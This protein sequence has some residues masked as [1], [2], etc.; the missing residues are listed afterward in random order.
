[1]CEIQTK[2]QGY[3]HFMLKEIYEQPKAITDTIAGRVGAN[4][5]LDLTGEIPKNMVKNLENIIFIGCGTAYHASLFGKHLL[6]EY[7][8]IYVSVEFASEYPYKKVRT[9]ERTLV[10]VISQSGET[11]DTLSAMRA[12]AAKGGKIL[13]ITNVVG[14][15]IARE[16]DAVLYT[17]AG[18]EVAVASTKAYVCQLTC[19]CLLAAYI[20]EQNYGRFDQDMI[21]ELKLIPEKINQTLAVYEGTLE[22]YANRFRDAGDAFFLGRGLDYAS[23]MEGQLKLKETTYIHGEALAGGEFRHGPMALIEPDVLVVAL[24]TQPE[25]VDK[26][27]SVLKEA[28]TRGADILLL[29]MDKEKDYSEAADKVLLIPETHPLL[30]PML[31]VVLMQTLAYYTAKVRGCDVDKPRNLVKSVTVE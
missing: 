13:A 20:Q 16:A 11:A 7:T 8:D 15:T 10:I 30:A 25:L 1:M 4:N 19:L 24:A 28:K 23:A 31:T 6:E 12:A 18:P 29:A 17:H 2:K 5:E 14:S 21:K 9:N 3:E 26:M 27:V 22:S